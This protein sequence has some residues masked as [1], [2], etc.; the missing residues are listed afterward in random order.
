MTK[1]NQL[2]SPLGE[3]LDALHAIPGVQVQHV[4][5]VGLGKQH[6][7]DL[8]W[9]GGSAEVCW[10]ETH[11]FAVSS[12]K[13]GTSFGTGHDEQFGTPHELVARVKL[14]IAGEM[15]VE[16]AG[17]WLGDIRRAAGVTQKELA[18]RLGCSQPAVA[19]QEH[20]DD[21]HL[22][23]LV[24]T[25]RALEV[26]LTIEAVVNGQR[27]SWVQHSEPRERVGLKEV[28]AND[29]TSEQRTTEL[30]TTSAAGAVSSH[31]RRTSM[32]GPATRPLR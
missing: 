31:R 23:A 13:D 29:A 3:A 18:R 25:C 17:I 1:S 15:T 21:V 11:G 7:V 6:Y 16:R 5:P 30:V 4:A 10:S 32:G 9:P 27:M 26:G 12:H 8:E 28:V 24:R 19:Q 22:A 20:R 2:A 14:L